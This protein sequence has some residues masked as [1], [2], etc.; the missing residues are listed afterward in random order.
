MCNLTTPAAIDWSSGGVLWRAC[1]GA[2]V[3][4]LLRWCSLSVWH[5]RSN[6][7]RAWSGDADESVIAAELQKHAVI[8]VCPLTNCGV[9]KGAALRGG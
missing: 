2:A 4:V 7:S 8:V 3:L 1:A 9:A 5:R 6:I